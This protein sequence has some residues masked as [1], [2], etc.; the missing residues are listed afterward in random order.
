[1]PTLSSLPPELLY[2]ILEHLVH[3]TS[4]TS[5]ASETFW[6]PS[7]Y[8]VLASAAL[9]AR[10]WRAPAS[11]LLHRHLAFDSDEQAQLWLANHDRSV[12]VR[13]VVLRD[14]P[15]EWAERVL[16]EPEVVP[17]SLAIAANSI[18]LNQLQMPKLQALKTLLLRT[19]VAVPAEETSIHLPFNLTSLALSSYPVSPALL[20]ALL[21]PTLRVLD[22]AHVAT[23]LPLESFIPIF[24]LLTSL[25]LPSLNRQLLH[26]LPL[27]ASATSLVRLSVAS[28]HPALLAVIPTS[29]APETITEP[30]RR[31]LLEDDTP[32]TGTLGRPIN[33]TLNVFQ[34][35]VEIDGK[36][37]GDH[38]K[39]AEWWQYK[40]TLKGISKKK[41]DSDKDDGRLPPPPAARAAWVAL[42]NSGVF[43]DKKPAYNGRELC[44]C[45]K[46]LPLDRLTNLT[47]STEHNGDFKVTIGDPHTFKLNQLV[48]WYNNSKLSSTLG[49]VN[50]ALSALNAIFAHGPSL[51]FPNRRGTFFTNDPE[52]LGLDKQLHRPC[53]LPEG[54]ELW[55]GFFMQVIPPIRVLFVPAESSS[56]TRRAVRAATSQLIINIDTTSAAFVQPGDLIDFTNRFAGRKL[57][58]LSEHDR[59]RINRLIRHAPCTINRGPSVPLMHRKIGNGFSK[60]NSREVKFPD[61]DSGEMVTVEE[62]MKKSYGITLR[63]PEIPCIEF[64]NGVM[65][66]AELVSLKPGHPNPNNR[67]LSA[68]QQVAASPFQ[69][70][71][72]NDRLN[73]IVKIARSDILSRSMV[74]DPPT[75][76]LRATGELPVRDGTWRM[77]K[78]RSKLVDPTQVRSYAIIGSFPPG[79]SLEVFNAVSDILASC[80]RNSGLQFTRAPKNIVFV[81]DRRHDVEETVHRAIE[82]AGDAFGRRPE[83]LFW[84]FTEMV[85][86]DYVKFKATALRMGLPSQGLNM[87]NCSSRKAGDFAF[88]LNLAYKMNGK[89]SGSNHF[90]KTNGWLEKTWRSGA[91]VMIFGADI[92]HADGK[93]SIATVVG[94]LDKEAATYADASTIQPLREPDHTGIARRQEIIVELESMISKLLGIHYDSNKSRLPDSLI[95]YRDGGS[96]SEWGAFVSYELKAIRKG[97]AS[98]KT[99][100]AK[101]ADDAKKALLD[102]YEPKIT[103]ILAVKRHHVRAVVGD[104][105]KHANIPAGTVFD[106]GVTSARVFDWYGAAHVGIIGTTRPTRYVVMTEEQEPKMSIDDLQGLTSDLAH[107]YQRAP[108]AVSLPAPVY[109]ADLISG[110]L[111][112]MLPDSSD[113]DSSHATTDGKETTEHSRSATLDIFKAFLGDVEKGM[114]TLR[115]GNS[116]KPSQWWL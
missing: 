99:E 110:K 116:T 80:S 67:K 104:P 18:E 78:G 82:L 27:L 39:T 50:V 68:A 114:E 76:D 41:K 109:Y 11:Q 84:V 85:D 111:R 37:I 43:G 97:V 24:P 70:L 88:S 90:I 25:S 83:F 77:N 19:R 69:I 45:S 87:R 63:Y 44:Y 108:R 15:S 81:H 48:R 17:E 47:I 33:L 79:K 73:A 71:K 12:E 103:F 21:S 65:Y 107:L 54:L 30:L 31:P 57:N 8:E 7:H 36:A 29:K 22:L 1:M 61:G 9:V 89:N 51:L 101:T 32:A 91:S 98:F 100:R 3:K 38:D 26:F 105:G 53:V 20:P 56:P 34:M 96:E 13:T 42:E 2:D 59:V 62:Y 115:G 6:W 10:A 60:L 55:R 86:P 49:N 94:S 106:T 5:F 58:V 4:I 75:I 112:S 113:A 72:P 52:K 95:F 14:L 93:P 74:L 66:P 46:P 92:S 64:A 40:V 16:A 28:T 23:T 102:A 35:K